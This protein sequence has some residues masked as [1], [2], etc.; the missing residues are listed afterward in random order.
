M[1]NVMKFHSRFLRYDER[2]EYKFDCIDKHD[3]I[4]CR[5]L[6]CLT[7]LITPECCGGGLDLMF[8]EDFISFDT[9][10]TKKISNLA[11]PLKT[12]N[13]LCKCDTF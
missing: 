11:S 3:N 6:V 1:A 8:F 12:W 5:L 7:D 2:V 4:I 9:S 10:L 13:Q